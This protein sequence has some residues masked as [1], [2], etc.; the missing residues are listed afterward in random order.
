MVQV[1]AIVLDE[2]SA[3]PLVTLVHRGMERKKSCGV[4][5][6]AST[7]LNFKHCDCKKL[8]HREEKLFCGKGWLAAFLSLLGIFCIF[9]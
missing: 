7:C 9:V 4:V 5:S 2:M 1:Y 6:W 8:F 3:F